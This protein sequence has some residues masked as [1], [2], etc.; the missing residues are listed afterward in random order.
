MKLKSLI[1]VEELYLLLTKRLFKLIE[2]N[3]IEH[4]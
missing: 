4:R 1:L 2:K 3:L